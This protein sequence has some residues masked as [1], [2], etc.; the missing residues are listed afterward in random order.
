MPICLF[1]IEF[2]FIHSIKYCWWILDALTAS[3]RKKSNLNSLSRFL[4]ENGPFYRWTII[5]H[6]TYSSLFRSIIPFPFLQRV[7]G[8]QDTLSRRLIKT[9][10]KTNSSSKPKKLRMQHCI[11]KRSSE[12]RWRSWDLFF[13]FLFSFFPSFFLSFFNI[14]TTPHL[15]RAIE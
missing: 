3:I 4:S 1:S 11:A 9:E 13:F 12:R 5:A 7:H 2:S 10:L 8:I 6:T 15:T 14:W